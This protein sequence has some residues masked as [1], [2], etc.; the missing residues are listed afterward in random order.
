MHRLT[1]LH[2]FST[3]SLI[4]EYQK[5]P[6]R[7]GAVFLREGVYQHR[8]LSYA[9]HILYCASRK[10]VFPGILIRNTIVSSILRAFKD[11]PDF[12]I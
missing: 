4:P 2:S 5:T 7:K 11:P 9:E 8:I 12:I 6:S 10:D 3:E 1:P